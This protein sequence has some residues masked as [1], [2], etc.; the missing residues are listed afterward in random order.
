[1]EGLST[2][3]TDVSSVLTGMITWAGDVFDMLL[4]QPIAFI[5]C[6]GVPLGLAGFAVVRRLIRL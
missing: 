1:M 5:M 2:I 3:I 4:A 6:V